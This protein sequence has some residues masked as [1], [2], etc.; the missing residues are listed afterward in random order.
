VYVN[1]P[2][3][4]GDTAFRIGTVIVKVLEHDEDGDERIFAMAKRG[5]GF[6]AAGA[7]DWEWFE[8]QRGSGGAP[9]IA[10]RGLG[11]PEGSAYHETGT[12]CN[13]CHAA[14]SSNDFVLSPH[15]KLG[16]L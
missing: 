2:P 12:S 9:I 13:D 6:N 10:W 5:K 16:A 1:H 14:A 4:A 7:V 8:L 11:P 15:L 3:S